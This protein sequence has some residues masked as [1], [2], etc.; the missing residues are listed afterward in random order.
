VRRNPA[1]DLALVQIEADGLESAVISDPTSLRTGEVVLAVGNPVGLAGAFSVGMLSARPAADDVF[2]R[3]DIRLAPGN[4]GG[5]LADV[6]GQVVGI[7]SMVADGFG[8]AISS[9]AVQ[10][11]AQ[12]DAGARRASMAEAV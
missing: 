5:P 3:A 1:C 8:I 4:S 10:Q 7:N 2:L 12:A 9:R 6:R 11:F